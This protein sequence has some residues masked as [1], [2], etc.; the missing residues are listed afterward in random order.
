MFYILLKGT[1][2]NKKINIKTK[3]DYYMK[4]EILIAIITGGMSLLGV[5]I[6]AWLTFK[7]KKYEID[8]QNQQN[9]IV[10]SLPKSNS[11]TWFFI[12]ILVLIASIFG[13]FYISQNDILKSNDYLSGEMYFQMRNGKE[14]PI[15]FTNYRGIKVKNVSKYGNYK[16]TE[17]YESGTEFKLILKNQQKTYIYVIAGNNREKEVTILFPYNPNNSYIE[18]TDKEIRIPKSETDYMYLDNNAGK[19]YFCLLYSKK[20]LDIKSLKTELEQMINKS[21]TERLNTALSSKIVN[22]NEIVYQNDKI[23]FSAKSDK[24]ILPIIVIIE[25]Q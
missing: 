8:S 9:G 16:L 1:I 13:Y 22:S 14:M 5:V 15:K 18:S 6:A 4:P 12:F 10:K 24:Q 19:E 3:N 21:F 25:H 17:I 11:K 2:E 20:E 7:T 23:K